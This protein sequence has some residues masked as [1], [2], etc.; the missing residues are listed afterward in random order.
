MLAAL[1]PSHT[2]QAGAPPRPPLHATVTPDSGG[3]HATSTTQGHTR[4]PRTLRPR[5]TWS[6]SSRRP[7]HHL[8]PE[9]TDAREMSSCPQ[10]GP[11]SEHTPIE[12]Q[13]P[14]TLRPQGS[15]ARS[16]HT[17]VWQSRLPATGSTPL[18]SERDAPGDHRASAGGLDIVLAFDCVPQEDGAGQPVHLSWGCWEEGRAPRKAWS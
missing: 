4:L 7:R 5:A 9:G 3:A 10:P 6:Q 16:A 1:S 13:R 15:G 14:P 18:Q 2:H 8:R 12:T 17:P 11:T